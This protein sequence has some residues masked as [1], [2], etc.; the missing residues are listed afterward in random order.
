MANRTKFLYTKVIDDLPKEA[1][2]PDILF[3]YFHNG[4]YDWIYYLLISNILLSCSSTVAM[5]L[6][7]IE[8]NLPWASPKSNN[9]A[10]EGGVEGSA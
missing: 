4:M 7:F 6:R 3:Y 9:R 10:G 1:I 5:S 2:I 8:L